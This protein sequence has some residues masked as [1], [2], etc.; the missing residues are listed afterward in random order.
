MTSLIRELML[1][2]TLVDLGTKD[3]KAEN[4]VKKIA[5]FLNFCFFTLENKLLV[6]TKQKQKIL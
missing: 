3:R 2:A 4:K 1:A 5:Q 6:K